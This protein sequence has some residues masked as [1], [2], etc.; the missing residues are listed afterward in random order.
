M[1]ASHRHLITGH[2]RELEARRLVAATLA[3]KLVVLTGFYGYCAHDYEAITSHC[4]WRPPRGR[5]SAVRWGE[6]GSRGWW[7]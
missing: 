7:R 3:L 2:A 4:W 6:I 5:L 1:S